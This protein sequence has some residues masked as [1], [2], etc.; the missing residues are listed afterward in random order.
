MLEFPL[1]LKIWHCL[2]GKGSSPS[3]AQWVKDL[4]FLQLWCGLQLL[5]RFNSW[6][7]NFHKLWVQPKKKLPHA[8]YLELH[9]TQALFS[10]PITTIL[11][12][13]T[14]SKNVIVSKCDLL[15][16]AHFTYHNVF[17]IYQWFVPFFAI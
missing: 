10:N 14:M 1:W 6:S 2:G 13:L 17:E 15:R 7:G 9:Y 12:F 11:S 4:A 3:Q 16:L 5:L 8:I